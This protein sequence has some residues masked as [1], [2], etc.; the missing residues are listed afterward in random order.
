MCVSMRCAMDTEI[1]DVEGVVCA[2][3]ENVR[4]E[5]MTRIK[6]ERAER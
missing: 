4:N 6:E 5:K 3:E 1:T 2:A